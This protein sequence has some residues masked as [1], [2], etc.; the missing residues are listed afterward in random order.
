MQ[1]REKDWTCYDF[2]ELP[3]AI[4]VKVHVRTVQDLTYVL[5]SAW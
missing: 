5:N 2:L 3:Q 4:Y 1:A